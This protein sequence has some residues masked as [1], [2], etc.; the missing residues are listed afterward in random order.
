MKEAFQLKDFDSEIRERHA[1]IEARAGDRSF[2]LGGVTFTYRAFVSYTVLQRIA[3]TADQD[4]VDLIDAMETA[5]VDLLEEGQKEK[6][7]EVSRNTESPM[8]FFDLNELCSWMTEAQTGRPTLAPSPSSSGD[9]Q[10]STSSTEDSSSKPAAA[11][12][13]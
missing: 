4:G 7:L 9:A 5:V 12:A 2:L 11:S 6:F 13:A 10:T 1:E 8:T 3:A